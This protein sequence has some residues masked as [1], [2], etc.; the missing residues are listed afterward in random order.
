MT[1]RDRLAEVLQDWEAVIGLEIH[2]ELTNLNSKMFCGCR[3]EFGGEPNTRVCPVCLGLPG[4]LPWPRARSSSLLGSHEG[5]SL[6]LRFH[7]GDN[8][9][10]PQPDS[11]R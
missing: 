8:R 10:R 4:S 11:Q 7:P 9:C 5:L 1:T 3:V 2:T 6:A